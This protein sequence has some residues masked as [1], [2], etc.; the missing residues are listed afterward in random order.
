MSADGKPM[1][2]K[3]TSL[4]DLIGTDHDGTFNDTLKAALWE[5]LM[6]SHGFI[7]PGGRRA[8]AINLQPSD[9]TILGNA[10]A[11]KTGWKY[12]GMQGSAC[13]SCTP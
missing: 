11:A 6:A 1:E 8:G 10:W 5:D 12:K 7:P 2:D 4:V 9:L 3:S 13:C